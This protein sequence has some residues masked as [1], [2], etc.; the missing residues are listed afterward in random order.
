MSNKQMVNPGCMILLTESSRCISAGCKNAMYPINLV[1][2]I[3]N[4]LALKTII[5]CPNFSRN[6]SNLQMGL[7]LGP[8]RFNHIL[9]NAPYF[10]V[11][12]NAYY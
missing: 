6:N 7:M 3:L 1:K 5:K 11:Y 9:P 8:S 2:H 12:F 4:S 10:D